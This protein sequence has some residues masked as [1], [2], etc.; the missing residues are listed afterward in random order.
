[1]DL[2]GKRISDGQ[3]RGQGKGDG[4]QEAMGKLQAYVR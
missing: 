3:Q 4:K 1:M 2:E